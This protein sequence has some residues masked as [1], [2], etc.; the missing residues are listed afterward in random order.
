VREPVTQLDEFIHKKPQFICMT[1]PVDISRPEGRMMAT[2][3]GA[4]AEM[5]RELIRERALAGL[6]RAKAHGKKLGHKS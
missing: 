2:V 4:I 1:F 5:E 6:E 3:I